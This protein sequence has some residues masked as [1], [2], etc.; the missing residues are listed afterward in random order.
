MINFP[1]LCGVKFSLSDDLAGTHL[2]C[3]ECGRLVSVPTLDELKLI[4]ADGTYDI[5]MTVPQHETRPAQPMLPADS[6]FTPA[7]ALDAIPL[8]EFEIEPTPKPR[9]DPFTGELIRAVEVGAVV[10]TEISRAV[11]RVQPLD[12]S[13][14]RAAAAAVPTHSWLRILGEMFMTKNVVV[15]FLM[16]CLHCLI[17]FIFYLSSGT[18]AGMVIYPIPVIFMIIAVGYYSLVVQETGPGERDEIPTPMRNFEF[19][20]D[21]WDP[22]VHYVVA[23]A[24]CFAPAILLA[25]ATGYGQA[26]A[27]MATIAAV[28]GAIVFPAVF[29]TAAVDGV[30]ANFRPDRVIGVIIASGA[31]YIPVFIGWCL[32]AVLLNM[33]EMGIYGKSVALFASPGQTVSGPGGGLSMVL[34]A[35]GLYFSYYACWLLGHIWRKHHTKFPWVAQVF[36]KAKPLPPTHVTRSKV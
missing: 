15:L 35:A 33:G 16:W 31:D 11:P 9:Y 6:S 24:Y 5:D 13:K 27:V 22:L 1:C 17:A 28:I 18:P 36:I 30:I 34:V 19:R 26:G 10:E 4:K 2:Q 7:Q 12:K 14:N 32:G 20:F 23:M 21:L 3:K 29:L 25:N 8:D